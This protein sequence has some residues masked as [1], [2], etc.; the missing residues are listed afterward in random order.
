MIVLGVFVAACGGRIEQ[1][2]YFDDGGSGEAGSSGSSDDAGSGGVSGSG[3]SSDDGGFGGEAGNGDSGSGGSDA[4]SGGDAGSGDSGSGGDPGSGGSGGSGG[5][6]GGSGGSAGTGGMCQPELFVKHIVHG[7]TTERSGSNDVPML[8]TQYSSR[9]ANMVISMVAMQM[10][11]P[12]ASSAEDAE[13]YRHGK[14]DDPNAW[15][16]R[17]LKLKDADTGA[18]VASPLDHPSPYTSDVQAHLEFRDLFIIRKDEPRTIMLTMDI[19]D[20]FQVQRE[21]TRYT[22]VFDGVNVTAEGY[23][24]ETVIPIHVSYAEGFPVPAPTVTVKTSQWGTFSFCGWP[25]SEGCCTTGQFARD[26]ATPLSGMLFKGMGSPWVYYMGSNGRMYWFPTRTQ[27]GSWYG[28]PALSEEQPDMC[29]S[30]REF[31][32]ETV[33]KVA[34]GGSVFIRPGTYLVTI[35]SDVKVYVV[36]RNRT[37]RHVGNRNPIPDCMEPVPESGP[38]RCWTLR[39]S[40]D[41]L[42][43]TYFA[44]A[45]ERLRVVP[46]AFFTSYQIGESLLDASGQPNPIATPY[47]PSVEYDWG[48]PNTLEK[49]LGIIL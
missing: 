47:D 19:S 14:A 1:H 4:G 15:N 35:A 7:S 6:D 20:S 17:D 23:P 40:S 2:Y 29:R 30:V 48:S 22:S 41:D 42:A 3:G 38:L 8:S 24:K 25:T 12:D 49:E 10:V 28:N 34:Y 45:D 9:C 39:G 32:A 43:F 31:P 36:G 26:A 5:S 33:Q 44:D 46:D 37:L 13:P 21:A 16:M 18:I 11:S 27:L